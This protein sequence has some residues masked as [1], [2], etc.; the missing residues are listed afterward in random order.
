LAAPC[1]QT[2]PPP[3]APNTHTPRAA[4]DMPSRALARLP[5]LFSYIGEQAPSVPRDLQGRTVRLRQEGEALCCSAN[6]MGFEGL[7][8]MSM[9]F[10]VVG[11]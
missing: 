10:I 6:Q 5:V 9:A 8:F 11:S 4:P 1:A 2:P 7:P 3:H